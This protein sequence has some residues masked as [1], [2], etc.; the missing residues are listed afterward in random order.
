MSEQKE[1]SLSISQLRDQLNHYSYQY[2]VLD[3]PEIPDVE[4]DRLYRDLQKLE[5]QNPHLIT[6][7]S[8]TQRVGD[9]PLD[10]FQQV[11]HEVPMLSLNN[12][13]NDIELNEFNKRIQQRLDSDEIISCMKKVC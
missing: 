5:K 9:K 3:D 13:F 11:K 7:D 6:Q 4:Y 12:V 1:L 2:Y 8:P 10:G